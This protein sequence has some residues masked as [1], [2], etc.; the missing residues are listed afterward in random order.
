MMQTTGPVIQDIF[1]ETAERL[2]ENVSLQS[3][4]GSGW[5][6]VT[7]GELDAS[8][9]K[10]AR[11][12]LSEGFQKGDAAGIVLENRPE[13]AQIFLGVMY[14]GLVAV[15]LDPALSQQELRNLL[16]DSAAKVIFCSHDTFAKKVS[17]ELHSRLAKIVI[18]DSPVARPQD[19]VSFSEIEAQAFPEIALP[20]T[21]PQAP[22][23][24][25]YTSGTTATPKG[26]L[27]TH[28]NICANFFSIKKTG[29][30]SS[31]DNTLSILP[32]YHTYAF[33]TTLVVP[34]LTGGRITI[35][36]LSF[37]PQELIRVIRETQITV[38]IGIPH[39]FV[40]IHKA[41]IEGLKKLPLVL[42]PFSRFG[43]GRY[44][45]R[46]LRFMA[47][48]GARLDPKVC[49]DLNRWG[50]KLI[51]GYGLTEASP[52][53][54]LNPL[55]KIK[56]GS[57]GKPLPDIQV[58][59]IDPDNSGVGQVAVRGENVMQ[60][61]F[62]QPGLTARAVRD[63]WL[64][65]KDL[66]YLDKEGYLFLTGR[67]EELI[68]LSSGKNIY[69]EELEA[70]YAANPYIK[71]LCILEKYEEKFGH[72][73]ESL[74]AV[75]VPDLEYFRSRNE[76]NIRE[77]IRWE[78]DN[79]SRQLPAYAHIMGFTVTKEELPRTT[80]GKI[81]RFE[82]RERY[83]EA[84]MPKVKPEEVAFSEEDLR[85]LEEPA[86]RKIIKFLSSEL[87]KPVYLDSHLE[88]DLGIDS[89]TRVELGLGLESL[90]SLKIPEDILYSISTV[91]EVILKI[92]ELLSR[93]AQ[94]QAGQ[95]EPAS[96][97]RILEEMPSEE[98]LDKIGTEPSFF[99]KIA[100]WLFKVFFL[101]MFKIFWLLSVRGRE[102]LPK[103]GP[104][105]VS[106]NHASYLDGFAVFSSLP[107]S[108]GLKTYFIGYSAI[109]EHPLVRWAIKTGRLIPIDPN[110]NLTQALQA[111]AYCLRKKKIVCI[112]PEGMRAIDEKV[113][114]F[115]KGIGILLKEMDI[116]AV[117]VYIKGSHASWPRTRRL[118]RFCRI[119]VCFGKPA[120]WK[121]LKDENTES[122]GDDY[123]AITRALRQRVM[124]LAC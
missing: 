76:A 52:V 2:S 117:P 80:L 79:L 65:T 120:A 43:L 116:P 49:R 61:Y 50:L 77:K 42:R 34:L 28:N 75:V 55:Q 88:L 66:G 93:P 62:K 3:K 47:S 12:L 6:K 69:P 102:D 86:S 46:S 90:F 59:I 25:F 30:Y 45:G 18:L 82:V 85:L 51:E 29:V 33:M 63:G 87:K 17:P 16:L 60:G 107:F 32:F 53:V 19:L 114:E 95:Q 13:W 110:T 56:C 44:L 99:N 78:L 4:K 96:W 73:M 91:K 122:A 14:A 111:V 115:K 123:E 54:T 22:A 26:V 109:F 64:Y 89:L 48:G 98:T 23:L 83:L 108:L 24:L 119:R 36:G 57:A 71:E 68:V 103:D 9:Q 41:I 35:F 101:G 31:S 104:Y 124:R 67:E 5:Q 39:L 106:P 21:G 70:Y 27:L 15:P 40:L 37:K 20:Q 81:K 74:H 92:K 118:P 94:G 10:L 38:I 112:F 1:H 97:S 113:G 7:F 105:I 72:R 84:R 8:A 58:K 121:E 11:F 100:T